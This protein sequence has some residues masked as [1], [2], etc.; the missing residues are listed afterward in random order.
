MTEPLDEDEAERSFMQ[1]DSDAAWN[2][3][4]EGR[5][6]FGWGDLQEQMASGV[7]PHVAWFALSQWILAVS[8]TILDVER[9]FIPMGCRQH[10]T[11]NRAASLVSEQIYVL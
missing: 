5:K 1:E 2:H 4:Q 7:S 11:I 8:Y 9:E 3:E 10:G 6:M